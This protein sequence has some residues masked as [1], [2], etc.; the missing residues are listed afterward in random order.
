VN[1]EKSRESR[2]NGQ[3]TGYRDKSKHPVSDERVALSTSPTYVRES[4]HEKQ[5]KNGNSKEHSKEDGHRE[6]TRGR[7]KESNRYYDAG[8]NMNGLKNNETKS[9]SSVKKIVQRF[10][11][12][13]M[14]ETSARVTNIREGRGRIPKCALDKNVLSQIKSIRQDYDTS[15]NVKAVAQHHNG[16]HLADTAA[17]ETRDDSVPLEGRDKDLKTSID[18]SASKLSPIQQRWNCDKC[19]S[20]NN[21]KGPFCV[22][23]GGKSR[24]GNRGETGD[25]KI[26][27]VAPPNNQY[28]SSDEK[29]AKAQI[30]LRSPTMNP[31]AWRCG[32]CGNV[33]ENSR[34]SCVN[35]GNEKMF[36]S[37]TNMNYSTSDI[38][39]KGTGG[40]DALVA[41]S[42]TET[43]GHL[44]RPRTISPMTVGNETR[45]DIG[46]I[47]SYTPREDYPPS[48]RDHGDVD[49]AQL[50]I[51]PKSSTF[52]GQ[53]AWNKTESDQNL[54]I[55]SN[56]STPAASWLCNFCK[57]IN[58][59]SGP[60]CCQCGQNRNNNNV[61]TNG[62]AFVK[63]QE[64]VRD[65]DSNN[66]VSSR[67]D[68]SRC[69]PRDFM[70][71]TVWKCRCL[72]VNDLT[73]KFCERCRGANPASTFHQNMVVENDNFAAPLV[74]N[75][76]W[77]CSSCLRLNESQRSRCQF[78]GE[79][80][81]MMAH[82]D[83]I[84]VSSSLQSR[85]QKVNKP[86]EHVEKEWVCKS[87]SSYNFK[88]RKFCMNC[89]AKR[90]LDENKD[91]KNVGT[92]ASTRR[93]EGY[94][95]QSNIMPRPIASY[96][97]SSAQDYRSQELKMAI[98]G[99]YEQC[100]N[101]ENHRYLSQNNQQRDQRHETRQM[102]MH[103]GQYR[104]NRADSD[105]VHTST[106]QSVR[107]VDHGEPQNMNTSLIL[108]QKG[109][110]DKENSGPMMRKTNMESYTTPQNNPFN[111]RNNSRI[112]KSALSLSVLADI[113]SGKATLKKAVVESNKEEA[114][115]LLSQIKKG[116][117]LKSVKGKMCDDRSPRKNDRP[118]TI[119]DQIKSG[120]K[121]K[122]VEKSNP[123]NSSREGM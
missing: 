26:N 10:N 39:I 8:E 118:M 117:N 120:P 90:I 100:Q 79:I 70:Q 57:I 94:F 76:M 9:T 23:C 53:R 31:E 2:R 48:F 78:C 80:K 29:F 115:T 24:N 85:T 119:L 20:A 11:H 27:H 32:S 110:K 47:L 56:M 58:T 46:A 68:F 3:Q 104:V 17:R 105:R 7:L 83:S 15:E 6:I 87:C 1:G 35:C 28:R 50:T 75:H 54:S 69:S 44:R 4:K 84:S 82:N 95:S 109:Q 103:E 101:Y 98:D 108:P 113:S 89:G 19:G 74:Q 96:P 112:P 43:S 123:S 5:I 30:S 73:R 65:F 45:G 37:Q 25:P 41:S 86:V 99:P 51:S 93:D 77:E 14:E 116:K 13:G 42:E 67:N 121:L 49:V 72:H 55:L 12:K 88:D 33:N 122:K 64:A 34:K 102:Q 114:T 16:K 52:H 71:A 66:S 60:F 107:S 92:A 59:S 22:V 61:T 40:E 97:T 106:T 38:L 21:S 36:P 63:Q 81:T 62:L 111:D 18:T 91:L